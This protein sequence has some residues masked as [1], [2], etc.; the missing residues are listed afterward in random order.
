MVCKTCRKEVNDD[1]CWSCGESKEKY[2]YK[3]THHV[4]LDCLVNKSHIEYTKVNKDDWI[5]CNI[6]GYR[7]SELSNHLKTMHGISAK[8]YG[9]TKCQASKDKMKGENNPAYQHGGIL[10]PFSKKFKNYTDEDTRKAALKKQGVTR[11]KNGTNPFTQ[12]Y[13]DKHNTS[14]SEYQ[15]RDLNFFIKKYGDEEGKKR[16]ASKTE[17]WIKSLDSKDEEEKK[18]INRMK[19]GRCGAISKGEKEILKCLKNL[20]I[21]AD[22]QFQLKKNNKGYY[23]YDITVGFKIIEY[24]GDYWHCNPN[25]W[26]EDK[27]NTRLHMT[28]K[29]KWDL[30]EI[31]NL[32]A[33]SHGYE[34]FVIW[35]SDYKADKQGTIDKC[36]KFLTQ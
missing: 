15:T 32:H 33:R 10:S 12:E 29:E 4:C 1:I 11:K 16:H 27:F 20:G 5:E 2:Y 35:E 26:D 30:D 22:S 9:I 21:D 18:R 17:K 13:H 34:V 14:L 25:K 7:A 31:K 23:L 8:D 24:H 19:V 28:A 36:I 3:A 6:C